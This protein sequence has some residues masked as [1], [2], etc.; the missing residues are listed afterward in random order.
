[1]A[2]AHCS[3]SFHH[4]AGASP[5]LPVPGCGCAG[6]AKPSGVE[7]DFSSSCAADDPASE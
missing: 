5:L 1:M 4:L 3:H 7:R 6:G 2:A